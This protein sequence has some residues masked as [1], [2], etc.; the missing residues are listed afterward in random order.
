MNTQGPTEKA[1]REALRAS[2]EQIWSLLE[3]YDLGED[4]ERL[5]A[6]GDHL[7]KMK[8]K[9]A[10]MKNERIARKTAEYF[11]LRRLT[12]EEYA[13]IKQ[14]HEEEKQKNLSQQEEASQL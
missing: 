2:A 4:Q 10:F 1:A 8:V 7:V 6:I 3:H 9:N 11:K 13:E 12:E 5:Q 14:L